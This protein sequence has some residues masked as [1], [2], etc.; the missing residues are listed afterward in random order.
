MGLSG[1][2]RPM[3]LAKYLHRLEWKVY[4][5]TVKPVAYWQTDFSLLADCW[6]KKCARSTDFPRHE[7]WFGIQKPGLFP[8]HTGKQSD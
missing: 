1:V 4:V 5:L 2:Q 3:K 8:L 7:E 6:G